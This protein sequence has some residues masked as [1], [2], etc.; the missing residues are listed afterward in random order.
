MARN[1]LR[2]DDILWLLRT[3][4]I[5]QCVAFGCSNQA[6]NRKDRS[7]SFCVFPKDNRLRRA[8]IQ[9]V[10]RT[11]LPKSPRL[12]SEHFDAYC[13]EYTVRLQNELLGSCPWK[14][15]LKPEAIPTIFP[16]KPARS[17]HVV[18]FGFLYTSGVSCHCVCVATSCVLT[19]L[20]SL[21]LLGA[22][23][24]RSAGR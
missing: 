19:N 15:K 16:H 23:T 3:V 24:T 5:P 14:R 2:T 18:I 22:S 7:I 8:W 10:G 1:A 6:K 20:L 12:C 11:S 4:K 21:S 13:F 9:A 17:V